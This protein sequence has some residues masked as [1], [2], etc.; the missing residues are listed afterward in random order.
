MRN[1]ILNQEDFDIQ[2][3]ALRE[4]ILDLE[5]DVKEREKLALY[6]KCTLDF[7][8]KHPFRA[9]WRRLKAP[10]ALMTTPEAPV[11][12]S[13]PQSAFRT[14]QQAEQDWQGILSMFSSQSSN[15]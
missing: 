7:A 15:L 3:H 6:Y 11:D 14:R 9:L 1:M 4:R 8:N 2:I 13:R 10:F 12:E 5:H